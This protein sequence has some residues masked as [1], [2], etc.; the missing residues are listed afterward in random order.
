MFYTTE[1]RVVNHTAFRSYYNNLNNRKSKATEMQNIH[2]HISALPFA[3]FPIA[4]NEDPRVQEGS[5]GWCPVTALAH[6]IGSAFQEVGFS[7]HR[8]LCKDVSK[9]CP[10]NPME[11]P[12]VPGDGY[13]D[14]KS[15]LWKD[16]LNS[17]AIQ[18]KEKVE[19][20]EEVYKTHGNVEKATHV[21]VSFCPIHSK[22]AHQI[23]F[24]R[25][26]EFCMFPTVGTM[27][28]PLKDQ[29]REIKVPVSHLVFFSKKMKGLIDCEVFGK[30]GYAMGCF[31]SVS[32]L[33]ILYSDNILI[34]DPPEQAYALFIGKKDELHGLDIAVKSVQRFRELTG[35]DLKLV[36]LGIDSNGHGEKLIAAMG[37]TSDWVQNFGVV[38]DKLKTQYI[39]KATLFFATRM[40]NSA[41]MG[42]AYE[43][44]RCG[45][46]L[47]CT[48]SSEV[49]EFSG[50]E[51]FDNA[52]QVCKTR[53]DSFVG[54]ITNIVSH[55]KNGTPHCWRDAARKF[56]EVLDAQKTATLAKYVEFVVDIAE[57]KSGTWWNDLELLRRVT[58]S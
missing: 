50:N 44:I 22:F 16:H 21:F 12:G 24:G 53:L 42:I 32:L 20:I 25:I 4:N 33:P 6:R 27:I 30:K 26:I 18:M 34:S 57:T 43:A 5:C 19:E 56:A 37:G 29:G 17:L 38:A 13:W 23:G 36:V 40:C 55:T 58:T 7:V 41:S 48:E 11:V 46:P 51:F 28:V 15:E 10:T 14:D 39:S 1:Y 54:A 35:N 31:K 47:I 52:H 49:T 3:E 45:V 8:Y 9:Y 2:I